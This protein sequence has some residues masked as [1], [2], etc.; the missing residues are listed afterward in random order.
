MNYN[1]IKFFKIY[2]VIEIFLKL[3]TIFKINKLQINCT[4]LNE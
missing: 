1:L 4:K 3:N 2:T